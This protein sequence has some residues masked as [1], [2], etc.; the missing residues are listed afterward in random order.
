MSAAPEVVTRYTASCAARAWFS[1]SPLADVT[2]VVRKFR[3][4]IGGSI[5]SLTRPDGLRMAADP[6]SCC[7]Q[8][9][10]VRVTC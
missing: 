9:D 2:D 6:G 5:E 7:Q 10:G 4:N 8:T 3:F 1:R